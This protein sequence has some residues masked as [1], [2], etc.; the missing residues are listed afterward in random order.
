MRAVARQ[1]TAVM[2]SPGRYGRVPR[3]AVGSTAR[4]RATERSINGRPITRSKPGT[5]STLGRTVNS[6]RASTVADHAGDPEGVAGLQLDRTEAVHAARPRSARGSGAAGARTSGRRRVWTSSCWPSSAICRRPNPRGSRPA[7]HTS[8]TRIQ[9]SG[10]S[11]S[12]VMLMVTSSSPPHA[13][14]RRESPRSNVNAREQPSPR[15]RDERGDHRRGQR[16]ER[17]RRGVQERG[18]YQ[19]ARDT[20]R[21]STSAAR[22]PPVHDAAGASPS[23][24]AGTGTAAATSPRTS[25]AERPSTTASRDE[26]QPVRQDRRGRAPARR[27]G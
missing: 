7:G 21:G 11:L 5:S 18:G 23:A 4:E 2:G 27:R 6:C 9:T 20:P 13:T 10:S 16:G 3:S 14:T 26:Q 22:A 25:S 1:L 19:P 8:R 12:L 15:E 24:S 17:E